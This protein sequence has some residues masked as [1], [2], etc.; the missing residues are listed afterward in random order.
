[1]LY[2]IGII[3]VVAGRGGRLRHGW[4]VRPHRTQTRFVATARTHI[5]RSQIGEPR[6]VTVAPV[7]LVEIWAPSH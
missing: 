7:H 5:V 2:A 3:P 6:Q 1:M 4:A